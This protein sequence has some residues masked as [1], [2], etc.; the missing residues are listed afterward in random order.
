MA[1]KVA[2]VGIGRS[3]ISPRDTE[4]SYRELV[5][6]AVSN[7]HKDAGITN[8]QIP[9][10]VTVGEDLAE[11][12]A[13]AD[14]FSVDPTGGM[15]KSND[16]ICGD[17]L[18]AVVT[19]YMQITA[20][21]FDIVIAVGY[22]K[23]SEVVGHGY[24]T[25]WALE[26]IISR[27]FELHP[28]YVAGLEMNKYMSTWN[29]SRDQISS[30]VAHERVQALNN[31]G[32]TYGQKLSPEEITKS[33]ELC[34]PLH[35]LDVAKNVDGAVAVVLASE[36]QAKRITNK[37]VWVEGVG[38]GSDRSSA[39]WY[40]ADLASAGY[41][42]VA[43]RH[44]YG[45]AGITDPKRQIDFA[46]LDDRFSYKLP[47]HAEA[48][49]LFGKG[50]GAAALSSGL[51]QQVV[52]NASGGLMGLG[53]PEAPAGLLLLTEAILQLRNEASGRQVENAKRGMVAAWTGLPSRSGGVVVVGI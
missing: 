12:R 50:E 19:A 52:V 42:E 1:G 43:A 35:E 5:F 20:G 47:Q 26:P 27:S 13:I 18:Y 40:K 33:A 10:V 4:H 45:M 6:E 7:A 44:A 9:S 38:W 34:R 25:S 29:V 46:E 37:P 48:L 53:N 36:A 49:G 3:K 17:G 8:E 14:E 24:L 39:Y 21:L 32:A 22:Q 30:L 2:I 23:P 11:G 16:R 31:P 51:Q 15:L 41:L 28:Y